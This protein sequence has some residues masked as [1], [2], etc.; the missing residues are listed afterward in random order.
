[1]YHMIYFNKIHR[2]VVTRKVKILSALLAAAICLLSSCN[3]NASTETISAT[4][5]ETVASDTS[6]KTKITV[7][8]TKTDVAAAL[9]EAQTC[10]ASAESEEIYIDTENEETSVK[11]LETAPSVSETTAESS[12]V[13][14]TAESTTAAVTTTAA[15]VTSAASVQT[16]ASAAETTRVTSEKIEMIKE[17]SY[18]E[19]LSA[20]LEILSRGELLFSGKTDEGYYPLHSSWISKA[21]DGCALAVLYTC[22]EPEHKNWGILGWSAEAGGN[23][24]NG[25]SVNADSFIP[26]KT[27]L[28]IYTMSDLTEMFGVSDISKIS[29]VNLGAWSGGRI[30]GLYFLDKKTAAELSEYEEQVR[31]SRKIIHTYDGDLSNENAI[32]SAEKVYS[33]LKEAYKSSCLTGQ[34]ES[35]W[36]GSPDYEMNYIEKNT[37]KLPAIRGLDFMCNDFEGVVS[38]A[39]K[40]WN[41]G[42]IVTICWHTGADFASE[43]TDS[44]ADD[45]NWNEAFIEGSETYNNLLAGMDR[46]VPYLQQLEDADIPVLWRPFHEIDGGWFWWSKGG[47]ENFKKLWQMMYTR[48]T[49]YWGLDNLIW[50]L[51]YSSNVNVDKAEWY[52][53]D[54]Y[55]DLMGADSYESG[56]NKALYDL[57]V[58]I[59]PAGMPIVY[60]ECANIPSADA[61][62]ASD[63]LWTFFMVW[64]TDSLTDT[65]LNSIANLKEIYNSDYFITLDELPDFT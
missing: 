46:A 35:T 64:H 26:D 3:E 44:L 9:T 27:R 6:A 55:V 18:E 14:T 49:D 17:I 45:I 2:E 31:A 51:G 20:E 60:H 39:E 40:W 16:T 62:T 12:T 54:D 4:Q 38:R 30:E 58:E 61:M 42:G 5:S 48:Y 23:Y 43:Y 57:C 36:M 41:D 52:P 59:A 21:E 53:G 19:Q 7:T 10:I 37:G 56:A 8:T 1:M 63:A 13:I 47:A 32:E 33:Y 15:T 24:I 65:Q 29:K 25:E 34:M 22:D 50:V 11:Y 28:L